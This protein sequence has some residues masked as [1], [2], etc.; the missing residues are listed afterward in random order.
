M[1]LHQSRVVDGNM[2]L[3]TEAL[4]GQCAGYSRPRLA[5][6]NSLPNTPAANVLNFCAGGILNFAPLKYGKADGFTQVVNVKHFA[7]EDLSGIATDV[8]RGEWADD[9][10]PFGQHSEVNEISLHKLHQDENE[11]GEKEPTYVMTSLPG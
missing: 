7:E 11:G 4:K 2:C 3:L 1:M 5:S 9:G 8:R 10:Y 6:L